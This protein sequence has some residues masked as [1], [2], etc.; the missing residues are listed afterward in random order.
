MR[1]I[2]FEKMIERSDYRP[3]QSLGETDFER[4]VVFAHR[5]A[6]RGGSETILVSE[7]IMAMARE[8]LGKE[9][10]REIG[11]DDQIGILAAAVRKV[12]LNKGLD[13]VRL[14]LDDIENGQLHLVSAV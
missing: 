11:N 14:D 7:E 13:G 10:I 8:C 9:N 12:L 4:E 3:K 6:I 5:W 2:F 1:G